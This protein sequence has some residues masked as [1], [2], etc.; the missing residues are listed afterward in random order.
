[1]EEKG[2]TAT[3]KREHYE[4]GT[5]CWVNLMTTD[6]AGAKAFYGELLGWETEPVKQ[7]GDVVYVTIKNARHYNGGI[8]PITERHGDAPPHWLTYFTVHSCDAAASE[9]RQLGGEIVAGSPDL[10]GGR[11][12]VVNDPQHAAFALFE[13]E[14]DDQEKSRSPFAARPAWATEYN[15]LDRLTRRRMA[16]CRTAPRP[17]SA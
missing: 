5:F 15:R 13:G 16:P 7:N 6:S 9:V 1:M 4:P 8:M 2:E 11:I 14:T 17:A 12:A 10:G 3:G